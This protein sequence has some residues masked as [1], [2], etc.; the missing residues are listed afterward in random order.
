MSQENQSSDGRRT[1]CKACIGG[2]TAV[3]AGMVTY[4]VLSFLGRAQTLGSSKPVEVP[5]DQLATGQAQYA[6]VQGRQIIV[7]MTAEGPHVFG[8]ACSHL[9]CNVSWAAADGVF[10]CPCHGAVFNSSGQAVS[11]PVSAPLESIPFEIKEG[12]IVVT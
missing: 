9:G 6:E 4:P 2:L 3:S 8:A 12:K 7:L 5:L 10:R 11:G 1:F